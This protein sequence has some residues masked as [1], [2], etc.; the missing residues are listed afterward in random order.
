MNLLTKKQRILAQMEE[1]AARLE[2]VDDLTNRDVMWGLSKELEEVNREIENRTKLYEKG[3]NMKI[4]QIEQKLDRLKSEQERL[5]KR[6]GEVQ[7]EIYRLKDELVVE[8]FS[9]EYQQAEH[10]R[11]QFEQE[12]QQ[13]EQ[14][15]QQRMIDVLKEGIDSWG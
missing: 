11:R 5:T 6:L 2:K 15:R 14:E 8:L 10:K 1:E 9:P 13:A 7:A 12:R 4:N 3:D